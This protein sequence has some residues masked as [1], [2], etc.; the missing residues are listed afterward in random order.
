MA[1]ADVAGD[2][3]NTELGFN[4]ASIIRRAF[5]HSVWS[6]SQ[7]NSGPT[8]VSRHSSVRDAGGFPERS[9]RPI[10][11]SG[12]PTEGVGL[13]CENGTVPRGASFAGS[14]YAQKRSRFFRTTIEQA[15]Q[16]R[17]ASLIIRL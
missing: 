13:G 11:G 16:E 6:T 9:T 8:R 7:Q 17:Q 2:A 5:R 1:S 12:Y 3:P 14:E 4:I 10:V 15:C